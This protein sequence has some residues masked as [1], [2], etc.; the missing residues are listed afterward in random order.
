MKTVGAF[1]AKTQLSQ[2]LDRVEK[3]ETVTIRQ[4]IDEGRRY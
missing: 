2:L 1:Q 3:G 4:L